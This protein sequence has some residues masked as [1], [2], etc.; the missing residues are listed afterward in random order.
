MNKMVTIM[1]KEINVKN[2]LCLILIFFSI[3]F[4]FSQ[5]KLEGVYKLESK[6]NDFF[7]KYSF[8][9]NGIFKHES[10]GDLGLINFGEGH[11][12]IK[13][14]SL[15]LSYDLTKLKK[16]S[17]YKIKKYYN[18]SD[19]IQVKINIHNFD[20]KPIYNSFIYTYPKNK[21]TESNKNGEAFLKFKKELRND[22]IELHLDGEFLVKQVIYINSDANYIINAFMNENKIIGLSHPKAIK[23][24][25]KKFKINKINEK[26]IEINSDK[27]R[28][29]LI[30]E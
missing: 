13:N 23:N 7:A 18:D 16:E 17:Y 14:D 4:S 11:Y 25:I 19:S 5:K 2:I 20:N 10:F 27:Q 6:L 22:K 26:Q 8:T 12:F 30:K 9:K 3:S 29:R 15:I 1:Q 21:S 24:Q 28:I